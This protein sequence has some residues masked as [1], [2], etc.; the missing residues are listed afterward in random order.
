MA[1]LAKATAL[2][3]RAVSFKESDLIVTALTRE[4]GCLSFIAKGAKHPKSRFG[5]SLDLLTVSELVYYDRPQ[6]KLL[7]QADIIEGYWHL[8]ADYDRLQLALQ[9]ARRLLLLQHEGGGRD[10]ASFALFNDLLARLDRGPVDQPRLYELAFKLK[11]AQVL[12]VAPRLDRCAGC[13][14]PLRGTLWFSVERGGII[15]KECQVRERTP[16][17]GKALDPGSAKSLQM[18]LDLP[19]DKLDRLKLSSEL[20]AQG[21]I[22]IDRFL[23]YHLHPLR[24]K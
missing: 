15:G 21:E 3:L 4:M 14:A 9:A 24:P 7:S 17:R 22:L 8:K 2:I 11:L 10:G 5:A 20:I 19:F 12:G 16:R 13:G 1:K 6:L 18:A 23:A